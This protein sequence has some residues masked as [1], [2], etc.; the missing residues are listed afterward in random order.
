MKFEAGKEYK[1]RDGQVAKVFIDNS[2]GEY[3]LVGIILKGRLWAPGS[4]TIEGRYLSDGHESNR[5][6]M[7]AE[8]KAHEREGNEPD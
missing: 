2:S 1:T 7:P 5:D 8:D 4:W 3:P 6:L